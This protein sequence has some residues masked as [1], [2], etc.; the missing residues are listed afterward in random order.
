MLFF[1]ERNNRA[2][3]ERGKKGMEHLSAPQGQVVS[4]QGTLLMVVWF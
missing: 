4:G 2:G 3:Y 1:S